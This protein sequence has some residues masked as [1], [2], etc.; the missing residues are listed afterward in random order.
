MIT[1][2]SADSVLKSY[3]LSAVA[4][5][6]DKSVNPLLARIRKTTSDV[7]GKD[8]RKAV[9]FGV[10]GGIGA[11]TETGN[12]PTAGG[13]SYAQFTSS[14]KNLYGVIEISD[15]AIRASRSAEGAFVNLLND[16]MDGL[17]KSASFNFGRMLF[18]DGS[19]KL[20]TISSGAE[21]VYTVDSTRNLA[22]G[23]I[24]DVYDKSGSQTTSGRTV[25]AIDRE[26]N[27]VTLSGGNIIYQEG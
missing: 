23:M 11:G 3:Y 10:N 7:W 16:E 1:T 18:G 25:T 22:E 2:E 21:K 17:V 26:N 8:V 27:T 19:G 15:K 13:N 12:L 5:Q 14:L 6:L 9:R 20:A 24:V 4:D